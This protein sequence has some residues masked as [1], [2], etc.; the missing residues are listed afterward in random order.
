MAYSPK[1]FKWSEAVSDA[2]KEVAD[3]RRKSQIIVV[4]E[5]LAAYDPKLKA[6]IYADRGWSK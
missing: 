5:A 3:D 6:A 1:T 4:M 2:L